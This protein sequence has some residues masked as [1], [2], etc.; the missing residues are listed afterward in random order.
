MIAASCG[1]RLTALVLCFAIGMLLFE[2]CMEALFS[3]P[4]VPRTMSFWN[5][6][7]QFS[8]CAI[9]P[10]LS[11]LF[12][13]KWRSARRTSISDVERGGES[14]TEAAKAGIEAKASCLGLMRFWAPFLALSAGQFAAGVAAN[15]AVH[16]VDFTMKVVFKASKLLPTMAL[17]TFMGNSRAYTGGEYTAA[18]FL[19]GGTAMFSFGSSKE[20]PTVGSSAEGNLAVGVALL[21]FAVLADG[22]MPNAQQ[23]ILRGGCSPDELTLR[24]NIAG[25]VGG[26]VGL[27]ISGDCHNMGAYI[28]RTPV[29]IPLLVAGGL[30]FSASVMSYMRLIEEAGSVYAVGVSTVRKSATVFLSFMLFPGK[31][32]NAVRGAGLATLLVG[33]LIAELEASRFR[34]QGGSGGAPG[35][36]RRPSKAEVPYIQ[37]VAAAA[38]RLQGG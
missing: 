30:T 7:V 23:A 13:G 14:P 1:L 4:D 37:G 22:V 5:T 12:Q 15:H 20:T 6:T 10:A 9:V 35:R 2:I 29:V 18:I 38:G 17:S 25:A 8:F 27:A 26:I 19:C 16:F 31:A 32:F 3:L 21:V 33:L 11:T 36:G 34:R 28:E 24:V